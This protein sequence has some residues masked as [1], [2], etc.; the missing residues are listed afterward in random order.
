M[1]RELTFPDWELPYLRAV[2]EGTL[3]TL[4]ERVDDAERAILVRLEHLLR[5]PGRD[6]EENAIRVALDA[7]HVIKKDKLDFPHWKP[8]LS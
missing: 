4:R 7:L 1:E 5:I 2:S 6:T 8:D 3:E